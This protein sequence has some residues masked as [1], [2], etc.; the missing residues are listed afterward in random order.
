MRTLPSL[1]F[2]GYCFIIALCVV[3]SSVLFFYILRFVRS[4]LFESS[5]M[6]SI[7][8]MVM[9]SGEWLD[10]KI[11]KKKKTKENDIN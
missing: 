4:M 2:G 9:V 1:K 8:G 5:V 3:W 10:D 6:E 11:S 7:F